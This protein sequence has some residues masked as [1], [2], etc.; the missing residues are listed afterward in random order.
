MSF[1]KVYKRDKSA[2][3]TNCGGRYKKSI[4]KHNNP[5]SYSHLATVN[6]DPNLYYIE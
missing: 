2:N 5:E 1:M 4:K 3:F 6:Y